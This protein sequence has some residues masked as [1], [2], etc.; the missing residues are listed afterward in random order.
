MSQV[1]FRQ[2]GKNSIFFADS[3]HRKINDKDKALTRLLFGCVPKSRFIKTRD[4]E[5]SVIARLERCIELAEKDLIFAQS[6]EG[7]YLYAWR[8]LVLEDTYY[9][10]RPEKLKTKVYSE[11]EVNSLI[12]SRIG[13]AMNDLLYL[14]ALRVLAVVDE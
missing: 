4:L 1:S 10:K 5:F 13:G 8:K 12:Q 9:L 3:A 11:R 14:N 7:N 6:L 2:I